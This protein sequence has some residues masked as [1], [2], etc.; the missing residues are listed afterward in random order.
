[1][2]LSHLTRRTRLLCTA[3]ILLIA[4]SVGLGPRVWAL[5][6]QV[7]GGSYLAGVLQ[8]LQK[9]NPGSFACQLGPLTEPSSRS[10]LQQA[11]AHLEAARHS[12]PRLAQA[13]LLLGRAYCL[14]GDLENAIAA[15]RA[16]IRMRPQNPLGHLEI[17]M[18]YALGSQTAAIAAWQSAGVTP[19]QILSVAEQ[20]FTLKNYPSAASWYRISAVGVKDIPIGVLLRWSMAASI[21][22]Q[23]LP[24]TANQILPVFPIAELGKTRIE[25]MYFRWLR[26]NVQNNLAYGD[27]LMDR[28]GPDRS[29]G[30]MWWSGD[31]V[32]IIHAPVSG[33]YAITIRAQNSIPPPVQMNLTLDLVPVYPFEMQRGDMSWQEFQTEVDL[34]AGYHVIE[35]QFL[36]NAIVNG[37]DRDAV[38][39]WIEVQKN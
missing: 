21:S 28:P 7:R 12:D 35:L 26:D 27:R 1:M 5:Y 37:I 36:N 23:D 20:A 38:I 8:P 18:A 2:F 15:Y 22:G 3:G 31:A 19:A 34:S 13:A 6:Q 32:I 10:R 30:R 33:K 25:A 17:G 4:A 11:I 16:Y 29:V 24:D 39:E 9:S 14:D